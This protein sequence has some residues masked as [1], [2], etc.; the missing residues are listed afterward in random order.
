[1]I[2]EALV[3]RLARG[4]RDSEYEGWERTPA[5]WFLDIPRVGFARVDGASRTV[6]LIA[7]SGHQVTYAVRDVIWTYGA[8]LVTDV[9][10]LSIKVSPASAGEGGC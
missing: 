8:T 2:P 1:M 3:G 9:P 4:L 6:T 5:G 7:A 10:G